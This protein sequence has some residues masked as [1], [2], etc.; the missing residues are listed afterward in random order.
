MKVCNICGYSRFI[1]QC[2]EI[3]PCCNE[4]VHDCECVEEEDLNRLE[5][6]DKV[7]D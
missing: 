3:C 4:Y 2:H 1:C 6:F 5:A 7:E